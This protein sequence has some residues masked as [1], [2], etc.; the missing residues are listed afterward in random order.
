MTVL[1]SVAAT[2][3]QTPLVALDRLARGLPGRVLAKLETVNPGG[4]VKDRIALG[5]IEA[6]ER[7]GRLKP[8]GTVVELTSGNTGIGLG[9]VC[10]VKGYRM[11]AVMSEGNTLERRRMLEAV[12]A[13]VVLVPQ[14]GRPRPGQVS[15]ADLEKVEQKTR[16][17]VKRLK[18]FRPDQFL[19]P[20]NVAAHEHGTGR[21]IWEQTKGRVDAFCALVGTGGTFVG[22]ARALKARNPAIRCYAVEP[23]SAPVLAGKRVRNPRHK[24]Q[25]GGYAFVPPL[26][27]PACCDGFLT[28]TDAEAVRLARRLGREEGIC[29]GFSSG[30]NVIAALRLARDAK[31]G[32]TIVTVIADT[33][34]KYLSTDLFPA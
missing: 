24:L 16:E 11:V 4:S 25:G 18:A 30:A 5:I 2:I 17:L 9:I 15:G 21:E 12:G 8:G 1:P 7:D 22:V 23:A 29:A 26:W 6:A 19:N 13:E 34:L 27:E 32:E 20:D 33:G 31:P 28:A 10:A 14:A 3:G